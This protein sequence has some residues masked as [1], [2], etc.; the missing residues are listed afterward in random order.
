M[1][2]GG[3]ARQWYYNGNNIN[4]ITVKIFIIY[5]QSFKKK[6]GKCGVCGDNAALVNRPHETT[7]SRRFRVNKIYTPGQVIDIINRVKDI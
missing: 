3:F 4:I 5:H 6:A 2:C 1:N 7:S